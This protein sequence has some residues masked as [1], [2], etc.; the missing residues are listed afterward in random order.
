MPQYV[1]ILLLCTCFGC[2]C[3]GSPGHDSCMVCLPGSRCISYADPPG[4]VHVWHGPQR[5]TASHMALMAAQLIR[6]IGVS[7]PLLTAPCGPCLGCQVLQPGDIRYCSCS[8][9][10]WSITTLNGIEALT[11]R[12]AKGSQGSCC[13]MQHWQCSY[14]AKYRQC[15][16]TSL[17]LI[18]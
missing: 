6:A 14:A 15:N 12:L 11:V 5:G 2:T 3:C 10:F 16:R 17:W 1:S 8:C 7:K 18:S 4:A 13:I 9:N